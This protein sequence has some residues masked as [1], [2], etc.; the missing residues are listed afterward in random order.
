MHVES[1]Q[2]RDQTR[3]PCRW[4][5]N[6]QRSPSLSLIDI[7]IFVFVSASH[8]SLSFYLYSSHFPFLCFLGTILG[9]LQ[10]W[11]NLVLAYPSTLLFLPCWPLLATKT[12]QALGLRQGVGA[13]V[14]CLLQYV[15]AKRLQSCPT[16]WDTMDCSPPG[17]SVRGILQARIQEC[18]AIPVSRGSSPPRDQIL[19]SC[20]GRWIVYH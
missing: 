2:T 11:H 1:S 8:I 12:N 3:V 10:G 16:L 7:N 4:I 18:V 17:S 19:I 14:G 13:R 15:C 6:H 9:L 5:L 20:D